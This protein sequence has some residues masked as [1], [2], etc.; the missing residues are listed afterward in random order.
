LTFVLL[1]VGRKDDVLIL[2]TGEK[3]VP[4]PIEEAIV[5]DKRIQSAVLFGRGR[6]QVGVLIEPAQYE[7]DSTAFI[8]SVWPTIEAATAN[9][10]AFSRIFKHMIVVTKEDKPMLRA[11]KD[12]IK[13]KATIAAYTEEIDAL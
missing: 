3:T 9:S 4:G 13:K 2:S 6:D 7:E 11:D 8:E 10:P 12:T 5:M 1:S